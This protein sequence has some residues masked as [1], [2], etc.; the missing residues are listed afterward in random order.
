M[1]HINI[2]KDP[3]FNELI[4][5]RFEVFTKVQNFRN[6]SFFYDFNYQISPKN[7]CNELIS[8]N[9][10]NILKGKI[11]YQ[12]VLEND[13]NKIEIPYVNL[14]NKITNCIKEK[15]EENDKNMSLPLYLAV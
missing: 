9:F 4:N 14:K 11:L 10:I 13:H 5:V 15:F 7:S 12:S 2:R 6:Y 1:I 3:R 8:D